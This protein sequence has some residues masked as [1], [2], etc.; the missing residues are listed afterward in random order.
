M[1]DAELIIASRVDPARFREFYDRL[2]DDL[3]GYFYRRV[4]DAEVAA[5]LLAETFA[6]AG[7]AGRRGSRATR[8]DAT[9]RVALYRRLAAARAEPW[10]ERLT[11]QRAVAP[12]PSLSQ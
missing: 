10:P 9:G 3:L 11:S 5:D 4:L 12:K 7:P 1:T 8:Q 2:A 6:A